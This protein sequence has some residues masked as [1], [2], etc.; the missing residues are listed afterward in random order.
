MA[1]LGPVQDLLVRA[2]RVIIAPDDL[3]HELPF[4]ALARP[5]LEARPR[6]LIED[7]A[8]SYV[9]SAATLATL[10]RRGAPASRS[11]AALLLGAPRL[12]QPARSL[13]ALTLA[14]LTRPDAPL[15]A[16]FPALP[17]SQRELRNV[18]ALLGAR[19]VDMLSGDA[20]SERALR[21]RALT[22]YG[23]IHL[24]THGLSDAPGWRATSDPL[25]VS[26][27]AL[28]LSGDPQAPYDG[29]LRLEE[30]LSFRTQARLVV[31]SGCTTGRGWNVLGD[32]AYGLAGAFLST[33]SRA[34]MASM[35]AIS[36]RA[37]MALMT[38]FY[39]YLTAG[40]APDQALRAAQLELLRHGAAPDR[41]WLPPFYWA[42]FRVIGDAGALVAPNASQKNL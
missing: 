10:S 32:G 35:W 9:P 17:G 29:L 24:A 38:L 7:V 40:H 30:I 13:S 19:R 33:G 37:T 42:A 16:L 4:E 5:T 2:K 41:P 34:V 18:R 26:Q 36:D 6:Y 12:S 39:D 20:A 31:L 8:V 3:L 25:R 28:L 15:E 1:L 23:L 27:P 21:E 14:P 22:D 11:G